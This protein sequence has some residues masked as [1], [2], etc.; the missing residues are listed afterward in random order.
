MQAPLMATDGCG[1]FFSFWKKKMC[2]SG[3]FFVVAIFKTLWV[4]LLNN[5]SWMGF[6]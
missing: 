5:N 1:H 2:S 4:F 3:G 6:S